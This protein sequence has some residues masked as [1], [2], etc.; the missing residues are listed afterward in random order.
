[1]EFLYIK[2]HSLINENQFSINFIRHKH[3]RQVIERDVASLSLNILLFASA[4]LL[5]SDELQSI[6]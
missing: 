6:D 1:M 2:Y 4:V 3:V 5:I